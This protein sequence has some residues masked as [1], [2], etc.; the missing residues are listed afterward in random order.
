MSIDV[1]WMD[2]TRQAV[3]LTFQPGWTWQGL[4]AAISAAD[5]LIGSVTHPVDL[6]ID[7]RQAGRLP[8]DFMQMAGKVFASGEARSNEGRRIVVGAGP[9]LRAAYGAFLKINRRAAKR[10]LI[11]AGSLADAQAVLTRR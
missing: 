4:Y 6:L 11:F 1:D 3:R 8:G 2:G 9:I 10:S 5:G 7:L